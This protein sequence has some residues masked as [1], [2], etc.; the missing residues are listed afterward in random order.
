VHN[1]SRASKVAMDR[2]A[3][4]SP[5]AQGELLPSLQVCVDTV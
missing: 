5:A 4:T 2:A 3:F 1:V